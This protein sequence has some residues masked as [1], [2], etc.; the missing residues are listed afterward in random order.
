MAL[1]T[2]PPLPSFQTTK[3]TDRQCVKNE[4]RNIVDKQKGGIRGRSITVEEW[5]RQQQVKLFRV[6]CAL[7][8]EHRFEECLQEISC[9]LYLEGVFQGE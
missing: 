8:E 2:P 5:T 7:V 4:Y 9:A 6:Q 3:L 1:Q